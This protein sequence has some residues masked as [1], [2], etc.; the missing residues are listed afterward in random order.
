MSVSVRAGA[1]AN[2][3]PPDAG[4]PTHTEAP[5]DAGAPTHAEAPT[6]AGVRDR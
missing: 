4:A 1:G 5:P 3:S 2:P 6:H